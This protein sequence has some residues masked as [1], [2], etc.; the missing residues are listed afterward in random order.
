MQRLLV[1]LAGV[2]AA[3]RHA[4][5]AAPGSSNVVLVLT[6]DQDLLF[7]SMRAMPFTTQL[8][9]GGGATFSNFFAHTPV[10]CPSRGE[11]LTVRAMLPCTP[12]PP[13][14]EL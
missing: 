5:L 3:A 13:G 14:I 6:D 10:C 9:G 12:T 1:V 4:V 8:L 7:E 11:L 2:A